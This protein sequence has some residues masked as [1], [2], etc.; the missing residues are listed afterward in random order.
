MTGLINNQPIVINQP[1]G[2]TYSNSVIF[3]CVPI[4]FCAVSL[5]GPTD[6]GVAQRN[7]ET[8]KAFPIGKALAPIWAVAHLAN[9]KTFQDAAHE[10]WPYLFIDI[11]ARYSV[12]ATYV[13]LK[14]LEYARLMS[15]PLL[16]WLL[17][18]TINAF[19]SQSK[20]FNMILNG[21]E[22]MMTAMIC[23]SMVSFS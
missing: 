13:K 9:V 10:R 16:Q 21:S 2:I 17:S 3:C 20:D 7:G 6:P 14:S 12:A 5:S 19:L 23:L 15:E 11:W 4:G 1:K 22:E 8:V 18:T